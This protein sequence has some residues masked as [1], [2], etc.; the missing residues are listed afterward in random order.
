MATWSTIV[1]ICVKSRF[2]LD[3]NLKMV[4]CAKETYVQ[5]VH[6]FPDHEPF[7]NKKFE[8]YDEMTIVVGKDIA[9]SGFG[10]SHIN[11]QA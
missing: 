11:V 8:M 5:E 2:G 7:L 10:R 4:M 3:E 6:A 1:K 9:T